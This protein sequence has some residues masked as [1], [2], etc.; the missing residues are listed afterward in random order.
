[1]TTIRAELLPITVLGAGGWIGAALVAQLQR[2]G[3]P[4]LAV[5]RAGLPAWLAGSEPQ[6]PVINAIGLTADFRQRPYATAEA[7]V[8]L[9]SQVL[10]R[11]GLVQLIYL[12]STRV[13]ARSGDTHETAALPCLSSDPSDLYNLSKLLGEA[14]VLQDPRPGLKVVRLSNVVGPGQPASTFVGALLAEAQ[15]KNGAVTIQQPAATTKDYVALADVVRLLPLIA[16]QGQQRLYNL[17]SGRNSSHAEEAAWLERQGLAVRFAGGAE[18][19]AGPSFPP[20]AIERLKAEFEPPANP[21]WQTLAEP[22]FA[23]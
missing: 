17:G 12:S 23:P 11:P 22:I 14:L 9:L 10:Q 16:E 5:N 15:A 20:L 21:F 1:M 6:G 13:Y 8:G 18:S 19:V 7:H 4:V 2:Q 3:R